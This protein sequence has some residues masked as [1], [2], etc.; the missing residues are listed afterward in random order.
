M[1]DDQDRFENMRAL[2]VNNEPSLIS[3]VTNMLQS[4]GVNQIE[5]AL[6]GDKAMAQFQENPDYFHF[7]ICDWTM[8]GMIG[9]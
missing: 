6:D 5:R 9:L 4:M 3:I 2:V 7:M 8:P 1:I